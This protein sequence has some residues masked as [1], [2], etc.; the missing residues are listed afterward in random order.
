MDEDISIINAKTRNQKI[1]DFF[2]NNKKTLITILSL[3]ILA[4]F[5][6]FSYGEIK[7]RKNKKLA[8]KYNNITIKFNPSSKIEVKN[9]LIDIINEKNPTY[10]P[11]ALYFIIDNEIESS[12]EEI[13]KF[14]DIIINQTNLD[15]EIKNLIVY[16]KALFNANFETENNLIKILNPII[17]SDSVWKSH[18]LYLLA[19]YFYD[20]NQKK[21][22]KEF[23]NQILNYE[24]SN[25]NILKETKKRLIRDLSE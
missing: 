19:E 21:K 1:K 6:F 9:E 11:L 10:S 18:A 22:A 5:I 14:F 7:E 25:E 20:K 16:K 8:E 13:N 24:K 2:I 15:K 12:N 3:I 4:I 17:N 23:Y